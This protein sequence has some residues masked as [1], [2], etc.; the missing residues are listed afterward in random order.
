VDWLNYHHLLYFWT[1][2]RTGGVS[3]AGAQLRLAAPTVSA[4]IRSLERSLGVTLL[5]RRG[6]N[7]VPTDAGRMVFRY[8]DQIFSLGREMVDSLR[9]EHAGGH[10]VRIVIGIADV[11]P[12]LI[13]HWL[14]EPALK[15]TP[16]VRIVCRED[17]PEHLLASLALHELDVVLTDAPIGP[18]IKVHA[19]NHLLGECGISFL[20][21]P[22]LVAARSGHF[23]RSLDRAPL[24][25]PT[26]NTALRRSLDQWFSGQQIRPAIIGEFEDYALLRVFGET[27]A[28]LFPAPSVLESQLIEQYGLKPLGRTREV[29]SRYYAISVEKTLKHPA[30]VAICETARRKLF[31]SFGGRSGRRSS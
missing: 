7:L 16:R 8:A 28:G 13:A 22:G 4:Q 9:E 30:V 21:T 20:G 18:N 11:L 12:K 1:V 25:L 5:E 17:N 23:P 31:G 10:P 3:A 6:R 15:L 27:G 2:V 26:D 29:R 24:L 14:I 19:Y